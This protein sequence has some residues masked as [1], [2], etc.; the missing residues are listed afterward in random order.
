MKRLL[1]LFLLICIVNPAYSKEPSEETAKREK[2]PYRINAGD[3]LQI[4]VY[5]EPDLSRNFRVSEDGK[6][7][8]PLLEEVEVEGLTVEEATKKLEEGLE[9]DYLVNPQ[10]TIFIIE[11]AKF[12]VLG[13][14]NRPGSYQLKGP[15]TVVD[16]IA[17]AGG[18]TD[19]A[20]PNGVRVVRGEGKKKKVIKVPVGHILKS[21]DRSKDVLL[22]EGDTI[23][24][25]ESFF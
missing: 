1:L 14:V 21:G 25:P 7:K 23:V 22:E 19:I 13:E 3:I 4:T 9:K 8:Y 5:Q 18:F 24:V 15:I 12:N 16:A 17:L 10:V 2:P 11:H 20:S 6:M